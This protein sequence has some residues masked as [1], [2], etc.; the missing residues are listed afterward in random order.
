M[1]TKMTGILVTMYMFVSKPS[2]LLYSVVHLYVLVVV[3][4]ANV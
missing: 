4:L 2:L 3:N 1:F